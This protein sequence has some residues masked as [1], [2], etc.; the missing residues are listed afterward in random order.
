MKKIYNS[1]NCFKRL[2]GLSITTFPL[3]YNSRNCFK[4]LNRVVDVIT[5]FVSTIVEI[6]LN[7]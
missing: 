2:N 7:D 3:I 1:R 4:R 5:L 6:V